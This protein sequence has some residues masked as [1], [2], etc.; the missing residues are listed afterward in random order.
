MWRLRAVRPVFCGRY[1]R[2]SLFIIAGPISIKLCT[3]CAGNVKFFR[4]TGHIK[5]ANWEATH[6]ASRKPVRA[7]PLPLYFYSLFPFIRH[8]HHYLYQAKKACTGI[9]TCSGC[10]LCDVCD[11]EGIRLSLYNCYNIACLLSRRRRRGE[12]FYAML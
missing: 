9:C 11:A 3:I 2:L 7:L 4:T 1:T 5:L 6:K 8:E 12:G 10:V